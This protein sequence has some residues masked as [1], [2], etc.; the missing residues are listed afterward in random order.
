MKKKEPA[1]ENVRKVTAEAKNAV[2]DQMILSNIRKYSGKSSEEISQRVKELDKE[3]DI[4]RVLDLSMSVLALSGITSSLLFNEASI[5]LPILLLLFFIWH[6][7][8]GWCPP[9]PLLRHFKIRTRPEID[10][11]KYALK[12]MRGDFKGLANEK[13]LAL[14]AFESAKQL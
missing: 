5:I 9:I 11:E 3:W 2:I 13:D 8:Q 6:A 10:R 1:G 14:W 7:F 4:E 12:A